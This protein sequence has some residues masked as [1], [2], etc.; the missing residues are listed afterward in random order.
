MISA[1]IR[2]PSLGGN[3]FAAA[4]LGCLCWLSGWQGPA[5]PAPLWAR[6]DGRTLDLGGGVEM[7]LAWI[8]PGEFTMGGARP[9]PH[10]PRGE[11]VRVRLT[12]GFYLG[13]TEITQR[14]W[15]AVMGSRPWAGKPHVVEDPG[16]PAVYLS[17]AELQLFAGR[18]AALSGERVRLPTEA[19]WEYAC[20]SGSEPE[21]GGLAWHHDNAFADP[22]AAARPVALKPPNSRGL[23]DMRGNV[24]EWVAD[25][26]SPGYGLRGAE[27]V[28]VDPRGPEEG[29]HRVKRGGSF[30]DFAESVH[31]GARDGYSEG[32]RY[33]N[34]G[35]RVLVEP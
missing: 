21:A 11:Q 3:T 15:T 6:D 1:S 34:I 30:Y 9:L 19:E 8:P 17:W 33:V 13:S 28:V 24:W 31:C 32:G 5:S 4:F 12:R 2:R 18:L 16:R 23:Y 22:P 27:G 14:Q 10:R 7:R 26:Y 20:R 25:W 29:R 35:A